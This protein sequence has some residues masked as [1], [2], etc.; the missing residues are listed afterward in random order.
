MIVSPGANCPSVDVLYT[1]R[2]SCAFVKIFQ[3][4]FQKPYKK[5][6]GTTSH[7]LT[8][9]RVCVVPSMITTHLSFKKNVSPSS[10]G[11]FMYQIFQPF[12][13][14]FPHLFLV[15]KLVCVL[16]SMMVLCLSACDLILDPWTL[17]SMR[18]VSSWYHL[19]YS[20]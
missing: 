10:C 12:F 14:C 19:C 17:T 3:W 15:V 8:V 7:K 20:H 9:F 4:L 5:Q 18:Q 1:N 13:F 2:N 11:L 6:I 16:T